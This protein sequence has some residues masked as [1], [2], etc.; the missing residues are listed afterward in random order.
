MIIVIIVGR[1]GKVPLTEIRLPRIARQGAV[2]L[3]STRGEA[4]RARTWKFE[5][6]EGFRPYRPPFRHLLQ[7]R[8]GGRRLAGH[9]APGP[10]L[11]VDILAISYPPLK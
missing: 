5:L 7:R 4:R 9:E 2:R 6:D 10:D 3:L 11:K 1:G 8:R